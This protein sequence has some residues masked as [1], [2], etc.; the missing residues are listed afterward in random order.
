MKNLSFSIDLADPV[1]DGVALA[2]FTSGS[3]AFLSSLGALSLFVFCFFPFS[4]FCLLV[5]IER[6]GFLD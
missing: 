6:L 3:N 1:F 5:G 2:G 4:S